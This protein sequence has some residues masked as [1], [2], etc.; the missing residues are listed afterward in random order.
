MSQLWYNSIFVN[1]FNYIGRA[2]RY[3]YNKS[4]LLLWE[5]AGCFCVFVSF[6]KPFGICLDCPLCDLEQV[7]VDVDSCCFVF[8]V[9][10]VCFSG[11]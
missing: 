10:D 5:D 9:S 3:M 1:C 6:C 11:C 2:Y 4:I 7:S 8:A